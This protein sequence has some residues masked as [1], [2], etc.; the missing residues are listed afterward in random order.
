MNKRK[1]IMFTVVLLLGFWLGNQCAY[2][3]RMAA[4]HSALDKLSKFSF[5]A[6]SLLP[7]FHPKDLV[8]GAIAGALLPCIVMLKRLE[9]KKYRTG[10]EHGSARWASTADIK[11]FI[12]KA[13]RNNLILTQTERMTMKSRMPK[14][15]R[16]YERNKNVLVVGGSGSGKTRYFVKPNIMQM[17]SS[18]VVTDP[19]G[20]LL[21]DC[22]RMLAR[23]KYRIKVL[24]LI[25]L[26][27][28]MHYNPFAYIQSEEDVLK[29]ANA[30]IANT[31]GGNTNKSG[32]SKFFEDAE[33]LY[34]MAL[35]GYIWQ[36]ADPEEKNFSTL[37]NMLEASEVRKD[38]EGYKNAVDLCFEELEQRD[39]RN[40]AVR[41]YKKFKL[42]EEE[43]LQ[44]ILISCSAR[45]AP[46]DIQALRD[47]TATDEMELETLGDE[48]TALFIMIS[49]TDPTYNFIAALMYTQMFNLLCTKADKCPGS[50]LP[51]H[52]RCILDEFANIGQIPNFHQLIS[53]IRSREISACIIL[54]TKSQL[55][56][57]YKDHMDTIVGNCDTELFLGG[58]EKGTVKDISEFMGRETID[59][60][61]NS[62]TRG[63]NPSYGMNYQKLGRE[64]MTQDEI[65]NMDR[66]NCI[67]QIS[68][69]RP[70]LSQKYDLNRHPNY[71]QL[72]D[73][74][75]Q[76]VFNTRA[77][78]RRTR[79]GMPIKQSYL[80]KIYEANI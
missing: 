77:Y 7:S 14:K 68:G 80:F 49:D 16:K 74:D 47:L 24:N 29:L 59:S 66:D 12:D 11:P 2:A 34:Y 71:R 21:L 6:F 62:D 44:N 13:F 46:F 67:L 35:I 56:A 69:V 9:A 42:S 26:S 39:P 65:L 36:E 40:F 57:L 72:A 53:T 63:N 5:A 70:F 50:R 19:K 54:Q 64:L 76:K 20:S 41:Q 1:A 38:I 15:L 32:D 33:R 48:K 60:F 51:I 3:W 43:T 31:S 78:L 22:G 10:R 73:D 75:P 61:N 25:D 37:L 17:H 27:Q 79:K 58:R 45:M 55:K 18:Y 30:L 8:A 4:G 52:V 23:N 28:S